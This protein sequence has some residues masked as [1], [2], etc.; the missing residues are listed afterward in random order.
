MLQ[1]CSTCRFWRGNIAGPAGPARAA[2]IRA[3]VFRTP[4]ARK[5]FTALARAALCGTARGRS[6]GEY[7]LGFTGTVAVSHTTRTVYRYS[8]RMLS[9]A[10]W[11]RRSERADYRRGL[12]E[13][14]TCRAEDWLAGADALLTAHPVTAVTLT[15][16]P[17]GRRTT[18][19][20]G[21]R[22]TSGLGGE[23]RSRGSSP[24]TPWNTA[25]RASRSRCRSGP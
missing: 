23:G 15:S 9:R 13:A 2:L 24:W 7:P 11:G 22:C 8:G 3:Q 16:L 21:G 1:Q 10:E 6:D 4:L 17:G 14:V 20:P 19:R 25:G 12:V 5:Q 18:C